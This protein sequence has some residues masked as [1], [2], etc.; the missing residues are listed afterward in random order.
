MT[1][2]I[3]D[4]FPLA[5]PIARAL[6]WLAASALTVGLLT[7]TSCAQTARLVLPASPDLAAQRHRLEQ[8]RQ[9]LEALEGPIQRDMGRVERE[10]TRTKERT[11]P[12][13]TPPCNPGG[14]PNDR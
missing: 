10:L 4:H 14:R 7:G 2:I 3:P 12:L 6:H 9:R 8:E 11:T 1:R 5:I 13:Q